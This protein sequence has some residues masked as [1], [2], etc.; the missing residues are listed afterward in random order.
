LE[1]S[2]KSGLN[3]PSGS[4]L[5]LESLHSAGRMSTVSWQ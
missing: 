4:F 1:I 2:Q 5:W 3:M